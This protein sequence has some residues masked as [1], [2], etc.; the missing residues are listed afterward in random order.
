MRR[1]ATLSLFG[2]SLLPAVAL[3][4]RGY[5]T[6]PEPKWL[7]HCDGYRGFNAYLPASWRDAYVDRL[8]IRHSVYLSEA[9]SRAWGDWRIVCQERTRSLAPASWHHNYLESA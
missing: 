7:R 3:P 6:E 5:L 1:P 9:L 2:E 8:L 4:F